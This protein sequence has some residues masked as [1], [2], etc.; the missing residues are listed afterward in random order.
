[1]THRLIR[2]AR[3]IAGFAVFLAHFLLAMA[4]GTAAGSYAWRHGYTV[5]GDTGHTALVTGAVLVGLLT[6]AAVVS[7]PDGLVVRLRYAVWGRPLVHCAACGS[8]VP[9]IEADNDRKQTPTHP[10]EKEITQ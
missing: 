2:C 1:M 9:P 8:I 3:A 6:A 5:P 4:A 7:L 10:A